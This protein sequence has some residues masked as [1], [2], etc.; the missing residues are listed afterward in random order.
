MLGLPN[1]SPSD[2]LER[3]VVL[4]PLEVAF[5]LGL[6]ITRG[7]DKGK[8]SRLAVYELIRAGRLK[9]VD[10]QQSI[11]RWTVSCDEVRRYLAGVS[12]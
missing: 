12:S 1:E 4:R 10:P 8:P 11:T 5:V 3:K 2:L 7:A 9:L 6:T